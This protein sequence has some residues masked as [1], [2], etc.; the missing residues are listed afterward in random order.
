LEG[1]G[2]KKHVFCQNRGVFAGRKA[3]NVPGA[4]FTKGGGY[5]G[6]LGGVPGRLKLIRYCLD[7]VIPPP[8]HRAKKCLF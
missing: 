3:K 4:R 8:S 5:I 6:E 1:R 2:V 7:T